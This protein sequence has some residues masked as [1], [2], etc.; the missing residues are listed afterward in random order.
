MPKSLSGTTVTLRKIRYLNPSLAEERQ[1]R[2]DS[3]FA[4]DVV[5]PKM[6]VTLTVPQGHRGGPV[7]VE[8]FQSY[9]RG[10]VLAVSDVVVYTRMPGV[11]PVIIAILRKVEPFKDKWWMPGGVWPTYLNADE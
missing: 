8:T 10:N 4:A 1:M 7:P 6:S 9:R 2:W 3:K 11:E 5:D